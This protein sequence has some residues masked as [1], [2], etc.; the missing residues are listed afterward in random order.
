MFK[1]FSSNHKG[2]NRKFKI[3]ITSWAKSALFSV[4]TSIE[5][6]RLGQ[7]CQLK[8]PCVPWIN[9]KIMRQTT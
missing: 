2:K 4:L 9:I 3:L 7:M 6:A 8:I 5:I 1:A